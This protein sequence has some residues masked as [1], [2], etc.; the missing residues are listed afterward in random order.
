MTR[1]ARVLVA[2]ALML[3]VSLVA[4][5]G[6]EGA[7]PDYHPTA[8][9]R[10]AGRAVLARVNAERRAAGLA[11]VTLTWGRLFDLAHWRSA[12][13]ARRRFIGHE[14]DPPSGR[15]LNDYLWDAGVT[16]SR[17]LENFGFSGGARTDARGTGPV[18]GGWL[19][20]PRHRAAILDP[21]VTLIAVGYAYVPG[22]ATWRV[23]TGERI[24]PVR[25]G[26]VYTL[27]LLQG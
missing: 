9:E 18:L 4:P 6:V 25:F 15:T 26:R 21:G 7:I 19:A 14:I 24:G 5:E 23:E 10:A 2:L 17:Y 20:S 12:T 3:S 8:A 11:R 16:G 13:M 1:R 22:R 27:L